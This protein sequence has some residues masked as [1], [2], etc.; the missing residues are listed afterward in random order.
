[1]PG[2]S[3]TTVTTEYDRIQLAVVV[4]RSYRDVSSKMYV[5]MGASVAIGM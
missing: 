5:C 2:N 3:E 4:F 1:M